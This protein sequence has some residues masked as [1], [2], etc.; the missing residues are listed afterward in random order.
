MKNFKLKV[1]ILI[2][3]VILLA[4]YLA[5]D[6]FNNPSVDENDAAFFKQITSLEN[7]SLMK[8]GKYEELSNNFKMY[9][10]ERGLDVIMSNREIRYN[11]EFVEKYNIKNC[12]DLS[13][14]LLDESSDNGTNFR[15]YKI[16]YIYID[17][18]GKEYKI[19][20]YYSLNIKDGKIDYVKIDAQKVR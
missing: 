16:N 4:T 12:K 17:N 19:T 13:V 10:N 7:Y 11:Y 15:E 3:I 8:E 2:V 1:I 14:E 20:D 9:C 6:F 18:E 5:F